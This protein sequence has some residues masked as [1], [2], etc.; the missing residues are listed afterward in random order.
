[1]RLLFLARFMQLQSPNELKLVLNLV[2]FET[3]FLL[4]HFN[5]FSQDIVTFGA[6]AR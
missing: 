3:G 1:M 4:T 5:E 2:R 6:V